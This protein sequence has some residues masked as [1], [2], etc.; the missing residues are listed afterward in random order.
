MTNHHNPDD[1]RRRLTPLRRAAQILS[2]PAAELERAAD[3]LPHVR[4]GAVVLF[5]IDELRRALLD[6]ARIK[7]DKLD[8]DGGAR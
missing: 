2:I 6:R 1:L 4:V 8:E 5:D 3:S 7:P